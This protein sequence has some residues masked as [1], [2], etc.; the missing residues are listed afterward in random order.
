VQIFGAS[1]DAQT[2]C[3]HYAGER[4]IVA[5]EFACCRRFYPCHLCHTLDAD[6]PTRLWPAHSRDELAVL[7]GECQRTMTIRAYLD[8]E[9]CP[10]CGAAFNPGCRAHR[11]R[12]FE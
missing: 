7:C 9:S 5:I 2:R 8:T 1:V 4:D 11:H 12:Y 10:N 3:V 6:H